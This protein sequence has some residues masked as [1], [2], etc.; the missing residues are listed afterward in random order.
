MLKGRRSRGQKMTSLTHVPAIA[1]VGLALTVDVSQVLSASSIINEEIEFNKTW[2]I[3]SPKIS[4]LTPSP[5]SNNGGFRF[6]S[7]VKLF[8]LEAR[9]ELGSCAWTMPKRWR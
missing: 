2:N 1:V 6:L 4:T 7:S 5:R 3:I 8:S 9:E